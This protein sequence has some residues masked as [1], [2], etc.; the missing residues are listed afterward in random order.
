MTRY[1]S[2]RAW[3]MS[4]PNRALEQKTWSASNR[5][6]V[7]LVVVRPV[8]ALPVNR[9]GVRGKR[10]SPGNV[11][12]DDVLGRHAT[13]QAQ[14]DSFRIARHPGA[15]I[16]RGLA[17]VRVIRQTEPPTRQPQQSGIRW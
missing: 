5:R 6:H 15:T 12:G 14:Q 2:F 17:A 3:H 4:S 10:H 11:L 13:S 7:E 1:S 16:N 8:E 9:K